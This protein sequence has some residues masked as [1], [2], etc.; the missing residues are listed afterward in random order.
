MTRN[1]DRPI[2]SLLVCFVSIMAAT[3]CAP[4]RKDEQQQPNVMNSVSQ[5]GQKLRVSIP[6]AWWEPHFFK[7]L[8]PY[9]TKINL[10]SLRTV[11]LP[12]EDDLEVRIWADFRPIKLDG[13]ILRRINNQWSAV[14]IYGTHGKDERQ[15]FSLTQKKL[16]A[17]KSGWDK[18]WEK[19]VG[20]GILTLPDASEVNCNITMID[21][22]GFVIE[23]NVYWSYRTY[24]YANPQNAECNEAKQMISIIQIVH[25]EF[26]LQ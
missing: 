21:G 1:N 18:A 14:H 24:A 3:A 10:P 15:D 22:S 5:G 12:N 4:G 13:I 9:T 2:I 19:L 25:D 16:A 6:D 8:E 26:P 20:A 11:A 17:P 7:S 23:T